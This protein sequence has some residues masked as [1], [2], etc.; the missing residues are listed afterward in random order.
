[1]EATHDSC[2]PGAQLSYHIFFQ[3]HTKT[4]PG[5]SPLLENMLCMVCILHTSDCQKWNPCLHRAN[6]KEGFAI[7]FYQP[8]FCILFMFQFVGSK[9]S[10]FN[11]AFAKM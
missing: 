1:M 11:K 9:E 3:N 4:F 10:S 6:L 7:L 8:T 5:K 2:S